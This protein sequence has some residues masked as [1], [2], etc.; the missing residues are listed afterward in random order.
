VPVPSADKTIE[1]VFSDINA[2][3]DALVDGDATA[4]AKKL[5]TLHPLITR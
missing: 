2:V 1:K 4:E 3:F 5:Y